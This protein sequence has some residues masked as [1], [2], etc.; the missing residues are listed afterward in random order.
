MLPFE[1][2]IRNTI[3][4]Q[5]L[6]TPSDASVI[7]AL[8]GGADSV[9]LL[10]VLK[11]L[12][13]R[14]LAAHC[15]FHLRA[16]ESNAD[17]AFVRRLCQAQGI[18]L[19]VKDV[20]VEEWRRRCG[21]SVEMAAREAR[22][23]WFDALRLELGAQAIAVAH[24]ADDNA[25]T[26]LLNLLRGTGLSGLRGM[27][28]R[29]GHV[30]R[31]LLDCR[32]ADIEQYLALKGQS[33]VTDSTNL[34]PLYTR[35]RLRLDLLP[36]LRLYWPEADKA[37]ALTIHHLR[38]ADAFV[39]DAVAEKSQRYLTPEGHIL[40][41]ELKAR[42]P[43]ASFLLYQM[44]S[45]RG[46]SATQVADML[47]SAAASGL[48]FKADG[49]EWVLDRGVLCQAE[50]QPAAADPAFFP[51]TI[52]IIE[53][54]D[55]TPQRGDDARVTYY[56]GSVLDGEPLRA[57]SWQQGDRLQ[58]FGMRGTKKVSD[59]F[60]NA[61]LGLHLKP[62]VPLLVKGEK[63]LWVAGLRR[64]ALYPVTPQSQ[65]IVKITFISPY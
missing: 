15:N 26:L 41:K 57:R 13:Y 35:N 55:F 10:L 8:S 22:Y 9:A 31:P 28:P 7:V 20:D 49:R 54:S 65:K 60:T 56:D 32:R 59:L 24:H 33:Y 1:L 45:S 44:L 18:E 62:S 50:P 27:L 30:V 12:G 51:F 48:I 42:E 58:P 5:S 29:N 23:Q 14:L 4:Q 36:Y 63:I 40:V 3:E 34:K 16:D 38:Q 25:E 53:R 61:K 46:F 37:L 2:Q 39:Q 21:G 17:E 64:S 19:R 11:A 6:L 47:N 52:E 43:H